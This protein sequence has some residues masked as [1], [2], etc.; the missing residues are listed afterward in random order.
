MF[1]YI[2]AYCGLV[3]E[4]QPLNCQHFRCFAPQ[5][6]R[7]PRNDPLVNPPPK[8]NTFLRY[9]IKPSRFRARCLEWSYGPGIQ[10]VSFKEAEIMERPIGVLKGW[11][12]H[13]D[14]ASRLGDLQSS[15]FRRLQL[16]TMR[17]VNQSTVFQEHLNGPF[18]WLATPVRTSPTRDVR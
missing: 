3:V 15:G 11:E 9:Q 12:C 2:F 18:V 13:F 14:A 8:K 1:V 10:L 7:Q 6:Q 5:T 17:I 16:E 4:I